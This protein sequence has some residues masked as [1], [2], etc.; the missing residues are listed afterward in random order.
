MDTKSLVNRIARNAH[1]PKENVEILTD[2]FVSIMNHELENGNTV[3]IK[4]FGTFE[5]VERPE[6]KIFNPS[7]RQYTVI[8]KRNAVKFKPASKLKNL[9]KGE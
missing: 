6:R 8:P 3:V 7:N 5:M 2:T 9:L 4:D 1:L